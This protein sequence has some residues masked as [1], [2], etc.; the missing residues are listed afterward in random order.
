MRGG[1]M[2]GNAETITRPQKSPDVDEKWKKAWAKNFLGDET[3]IVEEKLDVNPIDPI[4]P[5]LNVKIP[6]ECK[7]NKT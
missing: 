7:N 1:T 3:K 2:S 4:N 6:D 5:I